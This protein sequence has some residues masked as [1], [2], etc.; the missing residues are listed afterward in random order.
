MGYKVRLK[1]NETGEIRTTKCYDFDYSEYWWT[2]GNFGCDCNR[3]WGFLRAGDEPLTEDTPCGEVKYTAICAVTDEGQLHFIDPILQGVEPSYI[4]IDEVAEWP[5]KE[6]SY[7]CVQC[8]GTGD[9][10]I[11]DR[12]EYANMKDP[13]LLCDGTGFVKP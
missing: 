4:I 9:V 2:D 5:I 8:D 3:E 1:N 6:K 12:S 13:C 10:L 7:P 11:D